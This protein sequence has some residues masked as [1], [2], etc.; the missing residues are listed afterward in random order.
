[1]RKVQD[2]YKKIEEKGQYLPRH[3]RALMEKESREMD[4]HTKS[5][6]TALHLPVGKLEV[7]SE[8]DRFP[9]M[10]QLEKEETQ[11]T[12][13][14]NAFAAPVFAQDLINND[15]LLIRTKIHPIITFT[16]RPIDTVFFVRADGTRTESFETDSEN[17]FDKGTEDFITLHIVR[18]FH[19]HFEEI[20]CWW[21]AFQ[22][23]QRYV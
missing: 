23:H 8:K 5:A 1:M 18:K 9:F 17:N 3:V 19:Q 20:S 7:L 12:L 16:I 13:A 11:Q 15:F 14:T 4:G 10:G 21:G 6:D 22:Y 2:T